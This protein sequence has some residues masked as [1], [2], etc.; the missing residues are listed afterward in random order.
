MSFESIV[1]ILQTGLAGFAFLLAYLSY[2]LIA[3]EQWTVQAKN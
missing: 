1:P 3:K 2:R